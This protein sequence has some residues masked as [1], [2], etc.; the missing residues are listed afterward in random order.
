MKRRELRESIFKLLFID[1]FNSDDEMPEQVSLYMDTLDENYE[2]TDAQDRS[3]IERKYE[4]IRDHREDIDQLIKKS[5][6][7]WKLNRMSKVDLSILRLAIYEMIYDDEIPVK[8]AINEAVEL[9]K[10]FG[11]DTSASFINGIL[12]KVVRDRFP[13][14]P[15]EEL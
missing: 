13:E 6:T 12:G 8:V 2:S 3:Y 9:A 7:G 10:R 11:G 5:A 14:S 1:D 4:H 15:E